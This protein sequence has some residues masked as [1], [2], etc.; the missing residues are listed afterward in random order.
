MFRQVCRI[1]T[2]SS[3]M[4]A[5]NLPSRL[6]LDVDMGLNYSLF[7]SHRDYHVSHRKESLVV[8]AGGIGVLGLVII[9][10]KVGDIFVSKLNQMAEEDKKED[11]QEPSVETESDSSESSSSEART[12]STS[13]SQAGRK[14]EGKKTT[15]AG[16][17]WGSSWF[18]KN[19]YDG[20]FEDKMSRREAALI[21][22][23]RETATVERIKE[24]HRRVLLLNHP[25]RGGSAYVSAKINEAKDLLM[26][27]K[28]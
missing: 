2:R 27:G 13:S 5:R 17:S 25:D 26:K 1:R 11:Q 15:A 28:V 12:S 22:G 23:I 3:T 20:G 4:V 6:C 9:G 7:D 14:K 10:K 21:L 18:A 16:A 19:F 24:A 8:V